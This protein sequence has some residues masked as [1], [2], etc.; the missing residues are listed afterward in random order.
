MFGMVEGILPVGNRWMDGWS[1][2]RKLENPPHLCVN[3]PLTEHK[4][5]PNKHRN[6][7]GCFAHTFAGPVWL[8]MVNSSG[9]RMNSRGTSI[10][11]RSGQRRKWCWAVTQTAEHS[12][13]NQNTCTMIGSSK[14]GDFWFLK[15][16]DRHFCLQYFFIRRCWYLVQ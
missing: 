3:L 15:T 13:C 10:W 11:G 16:I 8:T 6:L 9:N 2:V 5:L 7:R 12:V 1:Q 4:P 14:H